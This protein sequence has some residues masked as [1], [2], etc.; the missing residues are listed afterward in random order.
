MA[1]GNSDRDALSKLL[2]M[3]TV[4]EYQTRIIKARLKAIAEKEKEKEKVHIIKKKADIILSLRSE[5]ASPD[6]KG[7][8]DGD[9]DIGVDEIS[10]GKEVDIGFSGGCDKPLRHVLLYSWDGGFD[11]CVDLTGSSP[12]TQTEMV[13]FVLDRVVI[14]ASLVN[15]SQYGGCLYLRHGFLPFSFSSLGKFEK[16]NNT[17]NNNKDINSKKNTTDKSD[18]VHS[19]EVETL[20]SLVVLVIVVEK[21]D[22]G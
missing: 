17:S 13:D 21:S 15:M 5:L 4:A 18:Y 7:S 11:V 6:I 14:D 10:A 9:E 1:S 19:M 8:L 20:E 2:Q 3:G 16:D 12:F 22:I